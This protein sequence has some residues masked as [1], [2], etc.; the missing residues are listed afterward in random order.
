M[1]EHTGAKWNPSIDDIEAEEEHTVLRF[2]SAWVPSN[3]LLK[4]LHALTGWRIHNRFEEEQPE[5]EGDFHAEAGKCH[6]EVRPGRP[7]CL[8]CDAQTEYDDLNSY[9]ECP[10]CDLWRDS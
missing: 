4:R 9:G 5:F 1:V 8:R 2:K 6:E 3:P 10:S 7:P